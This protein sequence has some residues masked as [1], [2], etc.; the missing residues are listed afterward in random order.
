MAASTSSTQQRLLY[1]FDTMQAPAC[2]NMAV[3]HQTHALLP[4][5][6]HHKKKSALSL[7]GMSLQVYGYQS[8]KE[9]SASEQILGRLAKESGQPC[10][11]GTKFF[12]VRYQP[13]LLTMV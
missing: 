5:S 11:L 4:S 6:Q 10:V 12:T 7:T 1:R 13:T 8:M 3:L 2:K 9:E